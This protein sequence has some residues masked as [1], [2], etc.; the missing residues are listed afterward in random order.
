MKTIIWGNYK[1]GVGKTTSTYQV[2]TYFAQHEKK[3]LLIDLDPQC[4]LSNICCRG[5]SSVL[6]EYKADSVLNYI[7]ELYM[8][9]INS[10]NDLDFELLCGNK[11]ISLSDKLEKICVNIGGKTYHNNLYFIPSSLSFENCRLNELAQ[12]MEKNIYNIFLIYLLIRDIEELH[13]ELYFDYLFI[14]CPPT[15][16]ILIQSSFLASDFYIVPTIIDEISTK[17]VADYITEIEKT[18]MKYI[19]NE[20]IGSILINSVFGNK[21]KLIGVFETIYKQR[22][23]Y[24]DNSG[25]IVSLDNNINKITGVRSIVS[26][27]KYRDYR[28]GKASGSVVKNIFGEYIGHR[29]NRSGGESIPQNTNKGIHTSSYEPISEAIFTILEDQK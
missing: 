16:N 24:A 13:E 4:S 14:D 1:G 26:D 19:M 20:N 21:T 8:R 29:D 22:R 25:Q 18:Y 28:D 27:E 12:R 9:Y 3:V 17:G 6:S 10:K 11:I 7:I 5:N 15:S 2:A 23:G